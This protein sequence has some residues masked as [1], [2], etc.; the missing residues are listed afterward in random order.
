M[1]FQGAVIDT[2][3]H[4]ASVMAVAAGEAE[5]AAIDAVTWSLLER[6]SAE[7]RDLR[8]LQSTRP[9]PGLPLITHPREDSDRLFEALK[10]AIEALSFQDRAC[11]MLKDIVKISLEDY[12]SVSAETPSHAP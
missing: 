9:T 4:R 2:G 1:A 12:L 5:L 3:S 11:L 10:A 6:D 8:I 7:T